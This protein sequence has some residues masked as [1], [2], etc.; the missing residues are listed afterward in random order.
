MRILAVIS[1]F[2]IFRIRAFWFGVLLPI[3]LLVS[4]FRSTLLGE[5][6]EDRLKHTSAILAI[7]GL[8]LVARS[9]LELREHFGKETVWVTLKKFLR[10][11][12]TALRPPRAIHASASAAGSAWATGRAS[13]RVGPS[14]DS[15][16]ERRVQILED[17][18]SRLFD[19]FGALGDEV[20]QKHAEVLEQI[21]KDRSVRE[22]QLTDTKALVE[23]VTIGSLGNE[24]I[25][26]I[27]LL[28]SALISGF[29]KLL[30]FC[31]T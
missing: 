31:A 16:L 26:W 22:K 30:N 13:V 25:G 5:S 9:F 27:W 6:F 18:Y 20:R 11:F 15:T 17:S 21:A 8:V 23:T 3:S 24:L 28:A 1:E 2:L 4:A 7:G 19:E 29:P 12:V 10:D 14:V